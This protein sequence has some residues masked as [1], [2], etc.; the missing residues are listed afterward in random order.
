M[1]ALYKESVIIFSSFCYNISGVSSFSSGSGSDWTYFCC[2]LPI[3]INSATSFA[4][5]ILINS[6]LCVP[7]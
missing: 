6:E 2:S 5:F 1:T 4:N 7:F 3:L